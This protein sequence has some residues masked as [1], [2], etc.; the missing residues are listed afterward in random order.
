MRNLASHQ[1]TDPIYHIPPSSKALN[2]EV[3]MKALLCL[4]ILFS[5]VLATF[6]VSYAEPA[7]PDSIVRVGACA[8]PGVAWGVFVQG[9]YA[10]IA[11]RSAVT[12]VDVSAPDAPWMVSSLNNLNTWALGV[13]VKDT[14]AHLNYTS[15]AG[16]CSAVSVADPGLPYLLDWC[17]VSLANYDVGG[18]VILDTLSYVAVA[19]DGMYI[20]NIADP[21]S[22][23]VIQ[24][25]DTPGIVFELAIVDS[26]LYVA[27]YDSLQV[28]N[29]AVPA[30]PSR[31]GASGMPA[32]CYAVSHN[33]DYVYVA[34]QSSSGFDGSLQVIS[35]SDPSSPQIVASVNSLSGDPIDLW[36]SGT[37]AYVA[38]ADYWSLGDGEERQVGGLR[39]QRACG[40]M[41]DVEGGVMV[42]DISDPLNPSLAASYDT[43]GDPRG[44]SVDGDLVF[45]ADYDSLQILRHIGV[46]VEEKPAHRPESP[47]FKLAQN[48]P[49]PFH[50]STVIGYSLPLAARV[51]LEVY[52]IAGRLV[53]SLVNEIQE[54]GVHQ[55]RWDTED[56]ASGMY[57]CKLQAGGFTD[58]KKMVLLR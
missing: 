23:T 52:D 56:K 32:S 7:M 31:I 29:V 20:I 24:S 34:C 15:L 2:L 48:H 36:I 53:E 50:S 33:G 11:D 58:I 16:R 44:I 17:S 49:N 37:H 41:A 13:F 54:P 46:G 43:P 42:I 40:L 35:V 14:V 28:L 47:S 3:L 5:A 39:P 55:V 6:G 19:E 57:F 30:S 26:L 18:I 4:S 25:Y 8:T 45:V 9:D 51:T 1:K 38:T 12:I 22:L 10:Y 21:S 27:D